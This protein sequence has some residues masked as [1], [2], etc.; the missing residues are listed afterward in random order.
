MAASPSYDRQAAVDVCDSPSAWYGARYG[1]V[2]P[3]LSDFG[4]SLTAVAFAGGGCRFLR[5]PDFRT[6]Q[7]IC[8]DPEALM[9]ALNCRGEF[10]GTHHLRSSYVPVYGA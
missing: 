3:V 10:L 5:E 6:A 2:R 7:D 8:F 1:Q 4:R 9:S